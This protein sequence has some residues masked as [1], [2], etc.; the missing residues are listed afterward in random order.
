MGLVASG[1]VWLALADERPTEAATGVEPVAVEIRGP[2]SF[3]EVETASEPEAPQGASSGADD[4]I[5]L[6]GGHW[7]AAGPD[8]K[9]VGG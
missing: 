7:V 5:Q 2:T 3:A 1:I 8:G 6:C 9:P 4:E